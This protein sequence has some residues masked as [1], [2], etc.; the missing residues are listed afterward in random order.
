ME[1]VHRFNL[2]VPAE[3]MDENRHANNIAYLH[4]MQEAAIQ[5]SA[6]CGATRLAQALGAT[7]VIRTHRIEYLSPAFAGDAITVE[8]WVANFRKV[9]SLRR[10]RFLR[11][12]DQTVLAEAETD[13]V[14]VDAATGHPRAIPG[15]IRTVF[16]VAA[17]QAAET[18]A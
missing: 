10:Y 12:A 5:H 8:T 14:F 9:R 7:W 15:E 3:V 4:W 1:P 16:G 13:W 2:T 6:I 11:A 17:G 18:R